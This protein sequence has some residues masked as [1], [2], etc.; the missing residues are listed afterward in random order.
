MSDILV[1]IIDNL[2]FFISCAMVCVS[3]IMTQ[4]AKHDLEKRKLELEIEDIYGHAYQEL[5]SEVRRNQ[6]D[7][8]NQLAAIY[9]MHLTATSL[10]DLVE[11]QKNYGNVLLEEHRYDR[12]LTGCNNPILAGYLYYRCV[13]YEKKNIRVDYHIQVDKGDCRL[14]LHEVIE[15]LGILLTNAYESY[16]AQRKESAVISLA[17]AEN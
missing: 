13:A 17:L 5:I 8:Q 10:E 1:W 2:M 12:I 16:Q 9:S 14:S 7:F 11:K 4:K 15:I 3:A 6:H